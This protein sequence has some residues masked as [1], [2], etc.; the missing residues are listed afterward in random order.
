MNFLAKLWHDQPGDFFVISSKTPSSERGMRD[1]WFA[2]ARIGE[3]HAAARDLSEQGRNVYFCPHGFDAAKR[4][5]AHAVDPKLLYSDL[6]EVDPAKLPYKPTVVIESSPGRYVGLWFTDKP[7]SEH[8]N[9]RMTYACAGDHGGWDRTQLLRVPGTRNWKYD[10]APRV[11]IVSSDGPSYK[12]AALDKPLPMTSAPAAVIDPDSFVFVPTRR[13][14]NVKRLAASC[15]VKCREGYIG[16]DRSGAVHR[17][18]MSMAELGA[19]YPIMLDAMRNAPPDS[20]IKHKL[21]DDVEAELQRIL[22]KR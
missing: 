1:T 17:I 6:D 9:K 15:A 4:Q 12:V 16:G 20:V 2:R 10:P 13:V 14:I 22:S 19:T 7:A 18:V 8:L 11:R 3:A 21:G 5:R